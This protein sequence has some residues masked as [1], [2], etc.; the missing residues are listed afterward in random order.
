[1]MILVSSSR[2]LQRKNWPGFVH[3]DCPVPP[4]SVRIGILSIKVAR[5]GGACQ[6]TK[7]I[8]SA[9]HHLVPTDTKLNLLILGHP[10]LQPNN[11]Y[12]PTIS[13]RWG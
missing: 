8:Y 13:V 4:S 6:F 7:G 5:C 11:I 3:T 9:W 12:F 2:L 10:D 1:M